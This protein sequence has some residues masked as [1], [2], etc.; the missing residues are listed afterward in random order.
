MRLAAYALADDAAERCD[1]VIGDLIHP[2]PE[3]TTL[4]AWHLLL[5]RR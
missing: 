3:G 5:Q 1:V 4:L 2:L